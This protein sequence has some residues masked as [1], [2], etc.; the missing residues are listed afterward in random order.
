MLGVFY[1][2]L[3]VLTSTSS[4]EL[5]KFLWQRFYVS[6]DD[7]PGLGFLQNIQAAQAVPYKYR[8]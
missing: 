8:N 3:G 5:E 1:A 2:F 6:I 7:E 4:D